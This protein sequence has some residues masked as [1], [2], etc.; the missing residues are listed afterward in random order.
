M[1]TYLVGGAVRDALLGRPV[2]DQD[3]V[4][5]GQ[6]PDAMLALGFK[7]VG[8]DFPVFLHPENGEE[9]ALA[10]TERKTG[11]GHGG[12]AFVADAS[13]TLEMDLMRRDLTINAIARDL[14]TGEHVDPYGGQVDLE[15][16]VLRHVSEA[17][18]EDPLRVLRV[19][20]FAARYADLGFTVAPETMDLMRQ[21]VQQGALNELTSERVWMEV[22]H[23][24][25]TTRPSRFLEVLRECGGLAVVAPEIDV[26]YGVPQVEEHHPEVDTGIHTQMVVDQAAKLA[27]GDA[28]VGFAA[29]V[30]DLG[31][32]LTDPAEWPK[33]HKHEE[34]GVQPVLELCERWRVP[35]EYRELAVA[36]CEHHLNAHRAVEVRPGTLLSLVDRVGAIRRPDR[37]LPFLLTCEA[38]ARGRLGFENRVYPQTQLMLDVQKAALSI[39]AAPFVAQGKVG[40]EIGEAMQV[41]RLRA[42][43]E[44]RDAFRRQQA[45]AKA[46]LAESVA[47]PAPRGPRGPRLK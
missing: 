39:T 37:L 44:V 11:A 13:V 21:M 46:A 33:H 2:K 20:R 27:P 34:N 8:K 42:V 30:H 35:T 32:G 31:K 10:R 16:R 43:T 29:L 47:T 14:E 23:A 19:A 38:D 7:A 41:A 18:A 36:V 40:K 3:F 45:E 4:V 9:Y 15:R 5:V 26:L 17:F 25:T 28:R 22:K 6:T 12:F 24:L 1:R